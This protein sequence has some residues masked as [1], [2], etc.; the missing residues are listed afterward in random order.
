MTA[1]LND[2]MRQRAELDKQIQ[3]ARA[4]QAS[5]YED[6]LVALEQALRKYA[7]TGQREVDESVRKNVVTLTVDEVAVQFGYPRDGYREFLAVQWGNDGSRAEFD[8]PL[9]PVAALLGLV[10]GLLGNNDPGNLEIREQQ[11]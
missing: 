1:N 10:R 7:E 4:G 11:P 2:M 6:A 3:R 9:P 5:D 8:G